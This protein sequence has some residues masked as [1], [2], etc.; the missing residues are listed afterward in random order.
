[1]VEY[2]DPAVV[3]GSLKKA[4]LRVYYY[5]RW[6]HTV[7]PTVQKYCL[8]EEQAATRRLPTTSVVVLCQLTSPCLNF[9]ES[10]SI[11]IFKK[12]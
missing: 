3:R 10:K 1:M 12:F 4:V 7:H 5:N 11:Y 6:V 9:S 8:I 2:V